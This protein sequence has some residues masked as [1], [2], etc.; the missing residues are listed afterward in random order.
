M[1]G[2]TDFVARRKPA[3]DQLA[4]ILARAGGTGVRRL[5][6]DDL[7]ALGPLYRRAASDLAY[8]RLRGADPNLVAY[9]NDLVGRAH[10]LLYAE[11]G[12]GMGRLWRFLAV[13]FPRVLRARRVYVLLAA[14]LL[15]LGSVVG[16][17]VVAA[18]PRMLATVVP[19]QFVDNDAHYAQREKRR[20]G[21]SPASGTS[22]SD[23]VKPVFSA[24]L[25]QNNIRVAFTAFALGMLGGFPTLLL[26]FYNGLPLGGL[27][28][29]QHQHGRDLLFWSLILPHGVIELTAIVIA[30]GAGM[31]IGHALVVPGE[32]SRKDALALA[33][34]DAVRLILG[35]LLLFVAAGLIESFISPSDLPEL[36]KLGFAAL[37]ALA[38]AAYFRAGGRRPPQEPP[39]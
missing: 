28:M 27:A 10:G 31:L 39:T 6:R 37:T 32:L 17:G 11:R 2:I 14:L 4:A 20:Q 8:A 9:L 3:W 25:M 13:G 38:L 18:N 19:A 35:T 34:R 22:A 1:A 16:A 21:G 5:G 30:G 7:R 26:L 33:G 36:V 15:L 24:Y 23:A 12:P 29:Q